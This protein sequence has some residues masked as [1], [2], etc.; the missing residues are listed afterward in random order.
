[1]K[2]LLIDKKLLTEGAVS[3]KEIDLPHLDAPFHFHNA[4]EI[5][6]IL[7]SVGR[8]VV[9]DNIED[10]TD[11]DLV[12]MGPDLPHLWYNEKQYY[13]HDSSLRVRSIVVYFRLDWLNE[14]LLKF[15]EFNSLEKLH[16][17]VSRG[18]KIYGKTKKKIQKIIIKLAKSNGLKRIIQVLTI[19][20]MVA[21]SEEYECLASEGYVNSYS[22]TDIERIDKIYQYVINN[23]TEKI[24]LKEASDTVNMT[25]NAFCRYF[26]TR[27][28]KTF[29]RFVNEVRIGYACKLLYNDNLSISEICY[30]CGF[31]NITNF[32]KNFRTFTKMSPSDFRS[33]M[34]R[35]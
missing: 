2:P 3:I 11:G 24:T 32:N 26:K 19:L 21:K 20:D 27:T 10:F 23:Y 28:Q 9:G 18:I 30:Q 33:R 16:K 17:N 1:M 35:H 31:N 34:K 22:E 6:L 5:V 25:P 15:S 14:T 8:R 29:T 7:E 13:R 12:L 4:Y